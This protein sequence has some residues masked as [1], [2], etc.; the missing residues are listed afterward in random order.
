METYGL[1]V[2]SSSLD[3][4]YIL[5]VDG[6]N[7]Y[8]TTKRGFKIS[9]NKISKQEFKDEIESFNEIGNPDDKNCREIEEVNEREIPDKFLEACRENH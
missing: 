9:V 8:R 5:C 4:K 3:D 6:N 7:Y 1:K 2:K